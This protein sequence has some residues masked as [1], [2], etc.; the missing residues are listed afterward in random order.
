VK[1]EKGSI[2]VTGISKDDVGAFAAKVRAQ[3]E[4][5]SY[6]GK[7]ICYFDEVIRRKQGK[8]SA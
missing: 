2:T 1:T 3:K 8:K 7:G 5:E 6:K 4:P